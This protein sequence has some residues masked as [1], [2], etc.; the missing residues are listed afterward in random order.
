MVR[1]TFSYLIA[2]G[3]K[4]DLKLMES[5]WQGIVSLCCSNFA[6]ILLGTA[7]FSVVFAFLFHLPLFSFAS[8]FPIFYSRRFQLKFGHKLSC[9]SIY[10][11]RSMIEIFSLSSIS[12]FTYDARY[13][14]FLTIRSRELHFTPRCEGFRNSC[15]G[16]SL[17]TTL[18]M[19]N[20]ITIL[21]SNYHTT[22][23]KLT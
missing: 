18:I 22:R 19:Q 14:F 13:I 17:L 21:C 20:T 15:S 2:L 23:T 12:D 7:F 4:N 1:F 5:L 8:A 6:Y 16:K 9:A 3:I 10:I 11:T